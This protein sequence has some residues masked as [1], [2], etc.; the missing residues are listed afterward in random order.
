M[1]RILS[2]ISLADKTRLSGVTSSVLFGGDRSSRI[3]VAISWV[4]PDVPF[5]SF[6]SPLH[7]LSQ[8][9]N[10]AEPME[11]SE[12]DNINVTRLR[13]DAAEPN[14]LDAQ[15]L[16]SYLVSQKSH[17]VTQPVF[18]EPMYDVR[19]LSRSSIEHRARR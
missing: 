19:L 11:L 2:R 18:R 9:F 8:V 10:V 17:S 16:Q 4:L 6:R 7:K 5:G 3:S 13:Y 1:F 15:S 12:R 14:A